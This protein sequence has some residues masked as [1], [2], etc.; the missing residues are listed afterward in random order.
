MKEEALPTASLAAIDVMDEGTRADQLLKRP[1]AAQE[2]TTNLGLPLSSSSPSC[3]A[4]VLS[5]STL[6]P[7][8]IS[9][10][11]LQPTST[12]ES[13]IAAAVGA[14]VDAAVSAVASTSVTVSAIKSPTANRRK[15]LLMCFEFKHYGQCG[16]GDRCKFSHDAAMEDLEQLQS[17]STCKSRK[18]CFAFRDGNCLRG[19]QCTFKHE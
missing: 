4:N 14:A 8:S 6:A 9:P 19:D 10:T 7:V 1:C 5:I 2:A 17:P 13:I 3:P 16:S 12:V 18:R 15:R 11:S